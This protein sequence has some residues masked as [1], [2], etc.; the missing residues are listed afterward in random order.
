MQLEL[1][2]PLDLH[3][4]PPYLKT[5]DV[6]DQQQQQLETT[7]GAQGDQSQAKPPTWQ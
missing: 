6:G 7:R 2:L 4:H 1:S 3:L 5:Y